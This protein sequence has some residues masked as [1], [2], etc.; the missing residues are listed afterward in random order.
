MIEIKL[1]TLTAIKRLSHRANTDRK[2]SY[3]ENTELI[4]HRLEQYKEKTVPVI[5]YYK[6]QHKYYSVKGDGPEDKVFDR[7]SEM[8]EEIKKDNY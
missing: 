6:K 4:V 5:D 1:P 3:D 7:L 2:R 8:A